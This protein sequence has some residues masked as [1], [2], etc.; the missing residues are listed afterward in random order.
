MCELRE[1]VRVLSSKSDYV[2]ELR[3]RNKRF[4]SVNY[5][6]AEK[7]ANFEIVKARVRG[8]EYLKEATDIAHKEEMCTKEAEI[9]TLKQALEDAVGLR[10]LPND[11]GRQLRENMY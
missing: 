4:V 5:K 9:T 6:L 3:A 11:V 7:A 10:T 8:L 2:D 1:K